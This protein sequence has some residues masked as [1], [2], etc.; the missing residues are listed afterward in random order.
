MK[1]LNDPDF[2]EVKEQW[3]HKV[4]TF[5]SS[6]WFVFVGI[7]LMVLI[8]YVQVFG[9]GELAVHTLATAQYTMM[10]LIAYIIAGSLMNRAESSRALSR[11]YDDKNPKNQ[12]AGAIV[13]GIIIF[14]RVFVFSA[15]ASAYTLFMTNSRAVV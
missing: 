13:F 5:I 2:A 15:I 14:S 6:R 7:P 1:S 12:L 3:H 10:A 8:G 11:A 9:I 4:M